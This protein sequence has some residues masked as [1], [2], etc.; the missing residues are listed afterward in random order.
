MKEEWN[1]ITVGILLL[2]LAVV[3][4]F[5]I[6][7]SQVYQMGDSG[8]S[9]RFFPQ[10]TTIAIGVSSFFLI[11]SNFKKLKKSNKEIKFHFSLVDKRDL[12]VLVAVGALFMFIVL[13]EKLGFLVASIATLIPLI[14]F[15]G[16]KRYLLNISVSVGVSAFVFYFFEHA[17][18]IVLH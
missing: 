13:F 11:L 3:T 12:K 9:P 16:E 6:I 18:K 1:N 15:F 8:L 7:P 2:L 5:V 4:Y 10:M 17:L 14:R